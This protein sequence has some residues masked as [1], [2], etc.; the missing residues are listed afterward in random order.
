MPIGQGIDSNQPTLKIQNKIQ[1]WL[2]LY[3]T[4]VQIQC[5]L[6]NWNLNRSYKRNRRTNKN[7]YRTT[8]NVH[9]PSMIFELK[10]FLNTMKKTHKE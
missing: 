1:S 10:D 3:H 9:K 8:K 6:G 2:Q 5:G 7:K 4:L